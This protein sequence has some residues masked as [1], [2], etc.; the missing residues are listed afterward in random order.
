MK[1]LQEYIIE[2][3][4][5]FILL[6]TFEDAKIWFSKVGWINGNDD[7]K[8][9]EKMKI[10]LNDILIIYDIAD[11]HNKIAPL[12]GNY[13]STKVFAMRRWIDNY[14]DEWSKRSKNINITD[15]W[16]WTPIKGIYGGPHNT[17]LKEDGS[18]QPTAEDMESVISFAYNHLSNNNYDDYENM[19]YVCNSSK[20]KPNQKVEN[21]LNYYQDEK[22]FMD[23][24]ANALIKFIN[25]KSLKL[26]KLLTGTNKN[27]KEWEELGTYKEVNEKVNNTP[28]TDII[29]SDN[30]YKISLKK[31]HGSQLMS[32]A[33]CESKATI[34]SA[35]KKTLNEKDLKIIE[36][37]LSTDKKWTKLQKNA[38]GISK[39]KNVGSDEIK[40][41]INDSEIFAKEV[42]NVLNTLLDNNINFKKALLYEAMTGEIKFGKDSLLTANYVFVWS[43]KE[44]ENKMYTVED[45]LEHILKEKLEIHVSWKTGGSTSYQTLRIKTK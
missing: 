10:S 19:N 41:Q 33:Y 5:D 4:S 7:S 39:Q 29:T 20:N 18:F 37:L 25:N 6:K 12:V 15:D 1:H 42:T 36:E 2:S 26:H 3:T 17:N 45:Y 31:A 40:K 22:K 27:T 32:G 35:A 16:F 30:N 44:S 11:E 14:L 28:K 8:L 13:K 23:G 9:K 21:L 43:S 24:C 38:K 34:L